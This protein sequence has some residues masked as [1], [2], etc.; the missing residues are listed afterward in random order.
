MCMISY[1]G[2]CLLER[3]LIL[4]C[5]HSEVGW[6]VPFLTPFNFPS[7]ATRY[8][9]AAGWTVSEP[10]QTINVL[11]SSQVLQPSKDMALVKFGLF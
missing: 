4:R 8:P 3:T 11:P 9:F 6:P 2:E 10:P 7:V 1:I 5:W